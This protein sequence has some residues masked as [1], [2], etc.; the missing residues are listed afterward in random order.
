MLRYLTNEDLARAA[1]AADFKELLDCLRDG[2]QAYAEGDVIL[3]EK[4]SQ[5]LDE[6]TQS[7][8]NCMPCTDVSLGYSGVKLVSVFPENAL[9]GKPN[10]SGLV[11]LLSAHDGAPVAVLDAGFLTSL[12]TALVGGLAA[13]Y[14]AVPQPAVLGLLGSGEEAFMHLYVMCKLFPSITECRVSS[15]KAS[16][17]ERFRDAA[18][19]LFPH[20]NIVCCDSDYEKAASGADIIVTAISGQV[21]LL[22]ADWVKPGAFYCHVGGIEDEYAVAQKADKI[23][24]DSWEAL[25]HRGSPTISHMYRDG[26]LSDS[27]I[28]AELD[29]LV[30]GKK[31]GRESDAEF[32]YF[33]SIGMAFTDLF[34][35]A[36]LLNVCDELGIGQPMERSAF[37]AFE[38][39]DLDES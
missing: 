37:N 9:E 11:V 28:Y 36:F 39:S 34:V 18:T 7:R 14:L 25:K 3:P 8:V 19:R 29:E 16:S 23:V 22:K 33:N 13:R 31:P 12:R 17:E 20:I 32:I 38:L 4:A 35:S 6:R 5:I 2:F 24:C 26:V 21:P 10:V 15:R 27:D 1:S 30:C